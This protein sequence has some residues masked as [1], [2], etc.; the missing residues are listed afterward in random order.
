MTRDADQSAKRSP[1]PDGGLVRT[2]TASWSL[3]EATPQDRAAVERIWRVQFDDPDD[4]QDCLE[5]FFNHE[6]TLYP[7]S[8]AFVAVDGRG[9]AVAFGLAALRN[10]GDMH[11]HTT[12]PESEFS[13]RDGYLYLSAVTDGWKRKGIATALFKARLE[14]LVGKKANAIYGVAWQNPEGPTSD[15]L[16]QKFG[17]EEIGPAPDDY[18]HGRDCVVCAD[19]C[20]CTGIIYRREL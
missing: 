19:A 13:G 7:F 3:Q 11:G 10:T 18:Y 5:E 20:D 4:H 12:L 14:W 1:R 17:F 2:T 6:H 8:K 9:R 16:F 15:P